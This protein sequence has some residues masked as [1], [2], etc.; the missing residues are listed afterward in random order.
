[1]TCLTHAAARVFARANDGHAIIPA[2]DCACGS[3][4]GDFD[5][6]FCDLCGAEGCVRCHE[7]NLLGETGWMCAACADEQRR[8]R[9]MLASDAPVADARIPAWTPP[10][11]E[12]PGTP[13]TAGVP[14]FPT[15]D[16]CLV[17]GGCG[18]R[19]ERGEARP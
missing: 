11:S 2:G 18:C 9:E 5:V 3:L 16:G 6:R 1:M 19:A 13:A 4:L 7:R 15:C 17:P 14:D 12:N 8:W 10:V